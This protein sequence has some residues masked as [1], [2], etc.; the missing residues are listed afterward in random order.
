MSAWSI[1]SAMH[2]V[3]AIRIVSSSAMAASPSSKN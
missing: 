2:L 3:S 1:G